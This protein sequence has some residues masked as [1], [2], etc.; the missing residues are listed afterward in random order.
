MQALAD[1]FSL[2]Y[3]DDKFPQF[4]RTLLSILADLINTVVL[5]IPTRPLISKSSS[6]F[7]KP[8][9]IVSSAPIAIGITIIF[10]FHSFCSL[11]KSRYL[12]LFS[13]AFNFT[14]WFPVAVNSTIWQVL[15]LCC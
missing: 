9:W 8:L 13:L 4:S 15:L 12:S 1:G 7:T 3:Y 14:L 6:S 5:M 11:A 2:K 10:M